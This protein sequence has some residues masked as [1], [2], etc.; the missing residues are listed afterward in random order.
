METHAAVN[1]QSRGSPS[2]FT[3][4]GCIVLAFPVW[5]SLGSWFVFVS[6]GGRPMTCSVVRKAHCTNFPHLFGIRPQP[7]CFITHHVGLLAEITQCWYALWS[8]ADLVSKDFFCSSMFCIYCYPWLE[9]A[10]GYIGWKLETS[11]QP[12]SSAAKNQWLFKKGVIC[13]FFFF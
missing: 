8:A 9:C 3:S 12:G 7:Y 4:M 2:L 10:F 5:K 6:C 13:V 1:V 11:F